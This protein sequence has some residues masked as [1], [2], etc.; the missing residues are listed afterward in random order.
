MVRR[1]HDAGWQITAHTCGDAA[2]DEILDALELAYGERGRH[3]VPRS[4]RAPRRAARRPAAPDRRAGHPAL[5]PA[6]VGRH[7]LGREPGARV[8]PPSSSSSWG[9]GAISPCVPGCTRSEAPTRPTARTTPTCQPSTVMDALSSATTRIVEP[10]DRP[11]RFM[12]EQRLG[13]MRAIRLL[14]VGGAYG[15]FAED[16]LGTVTPGKLADFVVLSPD[17]REVRGHAARRRRRRAGVR[18]RHARGL[19]SRLRDPLPDGP[20]HAG[21]T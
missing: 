18:G 14:T 2:T 13:L 5:D 9:V 16:D 12:R 17:P 10:G 7:R 21:P 4:A 20:Q 15:I 3:A 8:R 6:D 1:V 11:P 19:R